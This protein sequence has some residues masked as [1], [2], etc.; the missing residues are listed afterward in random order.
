MQK[1]DHDLE[2]SAVFKEETKD[3]RINDLSDA[4]TQIIN[5]DDEIGKG[6]SNIH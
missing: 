1:D 5:A 6:F 2:L 3:M 4:S